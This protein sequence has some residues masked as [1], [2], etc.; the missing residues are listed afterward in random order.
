MATT[1][2][3]ICLQ[4]TAQYETCCG[5]RL[6]AICIRLKWLVNAVSGPSGYTHTCKYCGKTGLKHSDAK[7]AR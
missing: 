6:C 7:A 2:T 1:Y 3:C 5:L 4:H